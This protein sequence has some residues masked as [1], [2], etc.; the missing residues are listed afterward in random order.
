MGQLHSSSK[1]SW[2]GSDF[3]VVQAGFQVTD[4][5]KQFSKS[6]EIL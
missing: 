2:K 5:Y 4:R 6:L 3:D 1:V